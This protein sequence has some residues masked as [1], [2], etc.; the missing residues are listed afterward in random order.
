MRDHLVRQQVLQSAQF[1]LGDAALTFGQ[2]TAGEGLLQPV[3]SVVG[4]LV[5]RGVVA[6]LEAVLNA[7]LL[8]SG[9]MVLQVVGRK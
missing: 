5:V 8:A 3:F 7:G 6:R 2:D 9:G 4:V 1:H